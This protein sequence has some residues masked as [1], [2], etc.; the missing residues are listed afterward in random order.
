M[1]AGAATSA[2]SISD[3]NILLYQQASCQSVVLYGPLPVPAPASRLRRAQRV[4]ANPLVLRAVVDSPHILAPSH[5]A[6]ILVKVLV[7]DPVVLAKLGPTQAAEEALDLIGAGAV[8]GE[9]EAVIDAL[10]LE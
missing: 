10:G 9:G 3:H 1:K 8:I 4:A 5:L 7:A 6:G 2:F